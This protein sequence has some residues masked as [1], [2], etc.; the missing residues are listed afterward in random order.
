MTE[1]AFEDPAKVL[2]HLL[3]HVDL[4][5]LVQFGSSP[6]EVAERIL[7]SHATALA[8]TQLRAHNTLRPYYHGGQE[9]RAEYDCQPRRLIALLDPE[10]Q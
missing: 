4:R 7:R 2:I 9:C 1:G 6:E 10:V 8:R 3:D 5:V